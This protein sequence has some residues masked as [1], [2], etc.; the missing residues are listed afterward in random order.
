[1]KD[2][3]HTTCVT[4]VP[5][6]ALSVV[7]PSAE[8]L[9]SKAIARSNGRYSSTA[10]LHELLNRDLALWFVMRGEDIQAAYTTRVVQYPTGTNG[11]VVDWLGGEEMS[12]WLPL[13]VDSLKRYGADV[14]CD[15]V[16][17][18]GRSGWLRALKS[19]GWHSEAVVARMEL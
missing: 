15:H 17:L 11:L 3:A 6:E 12:A 13:V 14:G 10:V 18:V 4:A 19:L 9:L 1:M 2:F 16:E 7:W 8:K 5:V